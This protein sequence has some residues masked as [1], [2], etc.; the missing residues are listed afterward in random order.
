[1]SMLVV[2][3]LSLVFNLVLVSIV[4]VQGDKLITKSFMI[5]SKQQKIYKLEKELKELKEELDL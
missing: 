2:L 4:D 5:D 3:I 1:M